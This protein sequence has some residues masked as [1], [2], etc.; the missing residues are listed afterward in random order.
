MRAVP[1]SQCVALLLG[2]GVTAAAA[3]DMPAA[4]PPQPRAAAIAPAP[5]TPMFW[6][7]RLGGTA[8]DPWSPEKGSAD[9]N[10]EVLFGKNYVAGN[11]NPFLPRVHVG[12]SANTASKTSYVYSGL[13]WTFNMTE[14]SFI[15]ASF[16]GAVHNGHTGPLPR[17]GFNGLGCS[18]L[19]RE[20][21]AIGYRI[22]QNWSVLLTIDHM[23]SAGL[24][25]PNRGLTNIGSKISYRF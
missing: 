23:S 1:L 22:S 11:P 20:S 9:V 25:D 17:D 18:P 14:R 6:E 24:C 8:H 21:G 7:V 13:T 5:P 2:A 15:E 12:A 19:F 10:G 3:A 4:Q 16:G